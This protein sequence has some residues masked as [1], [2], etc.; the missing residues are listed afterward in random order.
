MTALRA[1]VID[2]NI[3]PYVDFDYGVV[4]DVSLAFENIPQEE[5]NFEIFRR[6]HRDGR[7]GLD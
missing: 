6:P 3:K 4:P 5:R 1:C 2:R 7:L